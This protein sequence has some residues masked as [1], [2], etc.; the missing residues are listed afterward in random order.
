VRSRRLLGAFAT[1]AALSVSVPLAASPAGMSSAT[2]APPSGGDEPRLPAIVVT[3]ESRSFVTVPVPVPVTMQDL[4]EVE[5][6]VRVRGGAALIGSPSGRLAVQ[7][8]ASR[9]LVITLRV[10]ADLPAGQFEIAEIEFRANGRASVIQ[11]VTVQI[12]RVRALV[13][14]G[15]R[16]FN[17]LRP[18]DRLEVVYRVV[19]DGNAP[20]TVVPVLVT[21]DGWSVRVT[22]ERFL[23]VPRHGE[24]DITAIVTVPASARVGDYILRVGTQQASPS[25]GT[26]TDGFRTVLRVQPAP[27]SSNGLTLSPVVAAATSSDG[28]ATF[29]GASLDGSVNEDLRVNARF[30]ARGQP[31]G[32][33]TQGLS[34][35]GAI[36]MPL[37]VSV[38]GRDWEAA[39]GNSLVRLSDLAGVNIVGGGLT[40]SAE[41]DGYSVR[42]LAGRP[43][44][45]ANVSGQLLGAAVTRDANFGRIGGFASYL[46]EQGGISR[47]RELTAVG[48]DFESLPFGDLVLGAGLA[49]RESY[50]VA[51]AG[52]SLSALHQRPKDRVELRLTHAPGG[53]GAFARATDEFALSASRS[54]TD[55]WVVDGAVSRSRDAS[56]V[57]RELAVEDW[58]LAQR[59]ALT[60]T[61][62]LSARGNIS[63]FDARSASGSFGA[64][65]AG[66]RELTAGYEWRRGAF[67]LSGEGSLGAVSR[68]TDLLGGRSVESEAAQR[69]GRLHASQ[70]LPRLGALDASVEL[71]ST[72]AGVGVPSD[73]WI[74]SARWGGIPLAFLGRFVRL[75]AE[76][77][78]QR[79]DQAL[80]ILI[81]RA[82]L[83]VA[84]VGGL[85]IAMS[86]ERNPYY[87]DAAGRAGWTAA[88]RMS[89]ATKLMSPAANGPEGFVY[90]DWNRNGRRDPGEPGIGG[91]GLVRGE[92]RAVTDRTGRYRLPS[93][94]RGRIR[95]DQRTLPSGRLVH[96]WV[97]A[98][99][100]ER[101]D[102]PL[103]ATGTVTVILRLLP[104][105]DGRVPA[106]DLTKAELALQDESG[107][108]WVG[109][110]G[111]DTTVVF[112]DV[113]TGG[114]AARLDLSRLSEPLRFDEGTVVTVDASQ[115]LSLAI[116]LRGRS[117]RVIVPPTRGGSP[118][119]GRGGPVERGGPTA[120]RGDRPLS[121]GA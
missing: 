70:S 13:V 68:R 44:G 100:V 120:Q 8:A 28:S 114:Y 9:A 41:R 59:F 108:R 48:A 85:D 111:S 42:A 49:Y 82:T 75:D 46:T 78:Y 15:A 98:D 79:M 92:A 121:G 23:L 115:P 117:V 63:R 14:T 99:T 58:S 106:V 50:G 109:R 67:V 5:Y 16:E 53:S 90:D 24:A 119:G 34:A 10:P 54:L 93:R 65:G 113:P 118:R 32:I 95:V 80:A 4:E 112:Q 37:S 87:R 17:A 101:R 103:L 47:G 52:Y 30:L 62:M 66:R 35:V 29:L 84:Q 89:A 110:R 45:G 38:A 27:T 60:P 77:Q 12:P 69:S 64:F 26:S 36:G 105:D 91:V 61:S 7:R 39:A 74:A 11:P 20:E 40:A 94:V 2:G 31:S 102:I 25:D 88:V 76:T 57:F 104:D 6:V 1:V 33:L 56:A 97:T 19:N 55:K 107:F 72:E 71:Q 81:T 21:P 18:G 43:S 51:N 73:V 116:P 22:S 3:A 86:A 96:P 83:R